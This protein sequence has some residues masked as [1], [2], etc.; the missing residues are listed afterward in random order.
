MLVVVIVD[1]LCL[2]RCMVCF[3]VLL[4]CLFGRFVVYLLFCLLFGGV[5][6]VVLRLVDARVGVGLVFVGF[7]CCFEL[8]GAAFNFG[9]FVV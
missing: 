4:C 3:T 7:A 2:Y 6:W 8:R 9:W 1:C 5:V